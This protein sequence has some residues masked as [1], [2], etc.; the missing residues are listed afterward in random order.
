MPFFLYSPPII[1]ALVATTR[2]T[3]LL[4]LFLEFCHSLPIAITEASQIIVVLV[5]VFLQSTPHMT[6]YLMPPKCAVPHGHS[7]LA[8]TTR[9][10]MVMQLWPSL[11]VSL[12]G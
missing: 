10:G 1:S 8:G 11:P 6:I 5:S 12:A 4:R 9:V 7:P 2:P 3:T